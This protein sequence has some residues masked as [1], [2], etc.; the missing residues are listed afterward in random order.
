MIGLAPGFLTA[1]ILLINEFP[2]AK[3]DATTGK[4]HLVV[5]YGKKKSIGIYFIISLLSFLANIYA[6]FYISSI[7]GNM[8][9]LGV[10]IFSLLFGLKLVTDIKKNFASRTLVKSNINTIAL[11]ALTGL[12][13]AASIYFFGG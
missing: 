11:S 2:D 12:A 3:S 10:S 13:M 6:Y 9:F 1:N 8:V 7:N 5:T 4:N